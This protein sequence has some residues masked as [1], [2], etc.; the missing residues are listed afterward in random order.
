MIETLFKD[1]KAD[2]AYF[3]PLGGSGEIGMNLNLY[4]YK[5]NWL[6]VDCGVSF[7]DSKVIGADVF[8]PNIDAIIENNLNVCGMFITHAHE[9]HIGGVH[10]LWPH[11]R[12][13]SFLQSL[14]LGFR[15]LTPSFKIAA[16]VLDAL[17]A[18]HQPSPF[19]LPLAVL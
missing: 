17:L 10:H 5:D 13:E 19:F 3:L 11:I 18:R 7:K 4:G 1:K 16:L 9:D 15:N 14:D 6:I 2:H 8:M 12:G